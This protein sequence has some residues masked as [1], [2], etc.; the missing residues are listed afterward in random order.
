[1]TTRK[2]PARP[3][4]EPL[5]RFERALAPLWQTEPQAR[6]LLALSGGVDS[7]VLLELLRR[8]RRRR[9]LQLRAV[10]VN[11]HLQ[12]AAAAFAREVAAMCRALE[13]PCR[14]RHVRG[15]VQKG[16]SIESVARTARYALLRQEL[17]AG[18]FLLT[19][20]HLDDQA[21]TL[22]LQLFR[23]A[24]VDGLA[25]MPVET[26]FGRGRLLR[27]LLDFAREELEQLA[28]Q[29][30]M[31]WI[32]DPSNGDERFDRN[33]LRLRVMPQLRARW[34]SLPRVL[35]RSAA[36]LADAAILLGA[37]GD[38]LRAT[39]QRG[40]RLDIAACRAL[41]VPQQRL[42]VRSWLRALGLPSPDTR[43]LQ[44]ILVELLPAAADRHPLVEWAGASVW[45]DGVWMRAAKRRPPRP[46]LRP[47]AR[48]TPMAWH[49]RQQGL[50]GLRWQAQPSGPIDGARLPASLELRARAGGEKLRPAPRAARRPLKDLLREARIPARDRQSLP[51][52]YAD[53]QLLAVGTRFV[54]FDHPAVGAVSREPGGFVRSRSAQGTSTTPDSE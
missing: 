21:E 36:H 29:W 27:P 52:I 25:A 42:V 11:H 24:G 19:A 3:D 9:P 12:P 51:L 17:K 8:M 43:H 50:R 33:F 35:A 5:A 40:R 48:G 45:R 39:L 37:S 34:P 31:R 30:Q 49:W 15:L 7:R 1:V 4:S 41:A 10:H 14:I 2:P 23:G 44:R 46:M 18:E 47:G 32:E 28:T 53:G 22:L 20:H 16:V 26:E 13:V 38:A 54:N 6:V